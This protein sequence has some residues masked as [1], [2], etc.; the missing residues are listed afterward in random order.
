MQRAHPRV[1][2]FHRDQFVWLLTTGQQQTAIMRPLADPAKKLPILFVPGTIE[3]C[4]LAWVKQRFEIIKDKQA[5]LGTQTAN[6]QRDLLV[7]SFRKRLDMFGLQKM[8][9]GFEDL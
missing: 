6:Q 7:N 1:L 4:T 9:T 2:A 8:Q 3:T 5:A